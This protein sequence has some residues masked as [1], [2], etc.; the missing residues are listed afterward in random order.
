MKAAL[1]AAAL[2]AAFPLSSWSQS[3]PKP[4]QLPP[5]LPAELS[6]AAISKGMAGIKSKIDAC[7]AKTQY[8]GT[9]A[10]SVKVMSSGTVEDVK[11]KQSPDAS[12]AICVSNAVQKAAFA[13][14]Q[15]G[16]TFP[17]SFRF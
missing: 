2:F 10:L 6:Q 13:P 17:Y 11:V 15:K 5:E 7:A 9:V 4:L 14:S 1:I 3:K 8:Q 12:L 16:G